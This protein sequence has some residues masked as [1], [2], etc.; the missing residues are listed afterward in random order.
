MSPKKLKG[1][2]LKHASTGSLYLN[3][4]SCFPII[5]INYLNKIKK[6]IAL[7]LLKKKFFKF[8]VL[9]HKIWISTT[10]NITNKIYVCLKSKLKTKKQNEKLFDCINSFDSY[11]HSYYRKYFCSSKT[12]MLLAY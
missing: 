10:V 12:K 5:T 6:E 4:F 9:Q 11:H 8:R 3:V 2:R 7:T 1:K